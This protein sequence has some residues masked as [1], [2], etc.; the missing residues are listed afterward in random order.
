VLG[1]PLS[2]ASTKNL[3]LQFVQVNVEQFRS[4]RDS[5]TRSE[6]PVWIFESPPEIGAFRTLISLEKERRR[7]DLA[8]LV[9]SAVSGS[10]FT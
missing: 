7:A 8:N 6:Q 9:A 4:H 5:V 2:Q 1:T 3:P 10:A